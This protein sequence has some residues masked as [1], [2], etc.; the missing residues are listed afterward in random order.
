MFGK[1][2]VTTKYLK[3]IRKIWCICVILLISV[4]ILK[5]KLMQWDKKKAKQQNSLI[6]IVIKS[7]NMTA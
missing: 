1:A 5:Y 2:K 6:G 7:L 3:K 4:L